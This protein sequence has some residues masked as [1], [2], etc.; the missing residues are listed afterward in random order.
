[1]RGVYLIIQYLLLALSRK[2]FPLFSFF[3]PLMVL[4]EL[5]RQIPNNTVDK[6]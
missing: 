4:P 2:L 1:M 5:T 6:V 3:C